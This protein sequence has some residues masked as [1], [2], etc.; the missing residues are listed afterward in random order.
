MRG[1]DFLH[2][3]SFSAIAQALFEAEIWQCDTRPDTVSL[4]TAFLRLCYPLHITLSFILGVLT[5]LPF[6]GF[7]LFW[8]ICSSRYHAAVDTWLSSVSGLSKS[9]LSWSIRV[10]ATETTCTI[11][12]TSGVF[13]EWF[14]VRIWRLFILDLAH[15][16]LSRRAYAFLLPTVGT[17]H[18][19]VHCTTVHVPVTVCLIRS[20]FVPCRVGCIAM[21][22]SVRVRYG[23]L[24]GTFSAP[25]A[26]GRMSSVIL[27]ADQVWGPYTC[28][29]CSSYSGVWVIC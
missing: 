26:C 28:L 1:L 22:A 10:H 7:I 6:R 9:Y 20:G 24:Y 2:L 15:K 5:D 4:S 27:P 3:C 18:V 19:H 13:P 16:S 8:Y 29:L 14:R 23:R 25:S 17:L 21:F 12:S 11:F